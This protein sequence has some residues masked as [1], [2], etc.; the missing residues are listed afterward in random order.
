MSPS[1]TYTND[2]DIVDIRQGD[3]GSSLANDIHSGLNPP[4]GTR[5]S[6]PTM[7]LYDTKGLKLFEEITYVGEYYLTD[8][9]IDVLENHAKEIVGRIPDN[10]Q[11][12]ELG[13]GCVTLPLETDVEKTARRSHRSGS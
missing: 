7:L 4:D 13:S 2:V 6:L 9:E 8:A 3:L 12:L 10:A 5:R 1:A 11:L